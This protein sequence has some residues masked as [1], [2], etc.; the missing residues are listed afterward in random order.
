MEYVNCARQMRYLAGISDSV[1]RP[2]LLEGAD[3]YQAIADTLGGASREA[4]AGPPTGTTRSEAG[5]LKEAAPMPAQRLEQTV[6]SE[7]PSVH[8]DDIAGL[9]EAKEQ[10]KEAIIYPFLFPDEYQHFGIDPGGGILL[11]G[12]PGC[13]KTMLAAAAAA[14]CDAVF[15]NLKAS[16]IKNMYV[17][18]SEKNIKAAFGLAAQHRR[19]I[20]FFDEIDALAGE[21]SAGMQTHE[22]SLVS[23]LLAQMDSVESKGLPRGTLVLGATNRPWGLDVALR[24][25]GRFDTSIF[26]PHPNFESRLDVFRLALEGKPVSESVSLQELARRTAGYA[27]SEIVEV[28]E[29]AARIP[30]RERISEGKPRREVKQSDFDAVLARKKTILGP[31][32]AKAAIELAGSQEAEIFSDLLEAARRYPR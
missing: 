4:D 5:P 10:I 18:E 28:C 16:D 25:S 6:L 19:S 3:R 21:R 32:Y 27:S 24:R 20:I 30:L 31:W 13:G 17:G 29:K 26:I 9:S 2:E 15:I 7:K 23:E 12:P 14:E 22:R 1:Q 11:Y 8:F